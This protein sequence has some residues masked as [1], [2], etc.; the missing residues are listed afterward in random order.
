MWG[1]SIAPLAEVESGDTVEFEVTDASSAKHIVG[2]LV[3]A[4][5][6]VAGA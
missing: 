2:L 4:S 3:T 6:C 5:A 1:N